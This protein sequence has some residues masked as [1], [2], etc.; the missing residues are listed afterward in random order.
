MKTRVFMIASLLMLSMIAAAQVVQAQNLV[1]NIPFEFVMNEARLPA[2][3]Y[4]VVHQGY[5]GAVRLINR[6]DGASAIVLTMP[7]RATRRTE[8]KLIFNRYGNNYFLSKI[9]SS[10]SATGSQL[11]KSPR[12]KELTKV[13]RIEN[14]GQVTL[15]ARISSTKP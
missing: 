2:G 7:T 15:L 11:P 3:E 6:E 13:V 10:E 4:Y 1:A 5:N 8:S 14:R 9:W 12:E